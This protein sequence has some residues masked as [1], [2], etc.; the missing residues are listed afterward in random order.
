MNTNSHWY[1]VYTR[2]RHER[3]VASILQRRGLETYVPLRREWSRRCD[4]RLT[5]EV[6]ALPGYLFV[7]CALYAEVRAAIKSTLGVIH[8]IESGGRPI[9]IPERQVDSLRIVLGGTADV[10]AHPYLRIGERVRVTKGPFRDAAGYLVRVNAS[11]HRLVI[12]V[13]F[14]NQAVSVEIDA[15]CVER[16]DAS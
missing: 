2:S 11:T 6:P 16:E 1:G 12:A 14:V 5:I 7:R 15:A 4:R 13:Q 8:M 3:Q 9:A 10:D